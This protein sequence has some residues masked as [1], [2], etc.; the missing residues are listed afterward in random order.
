MPD[1]IKAGDILI[2]KYTSENIHLYIYDYSGGTVTVIKDITG[3]TAVRIPEGCTGL[4]VRLWIAQGTQIENETVMPVL[5]KFNSENVAVNIG[6]TAGVFTDADAIDK[7][8]IVFV[9]KLSNGNPAIENVPYS[10][11]WL[12]TTETN[13]N[14]AMQRVYP[15]EPDKN[16]VMMRTKFGGVYG[17]WVSIGEKG[18]IEPIDTASEDETGK[19]NMSPAIQYALNAYG[20]CKLGAGVYYVGSKITM[21]EGSTLE[22]CGEATEIRLMSGNN[23]VA[24][25]MTKYCTIKNVAIIGAYSD[26]AEEN[27]GDTNGTRYGIH[28]YKA[29]SDTYDTG[30][31]N[32]SGVHLRNFSGAGIYQYGTGGNVEQGLFVSDTHIKNCWA[33]IWIYQNSEFCRYS[34]V[35]ITYCK[36]AC[37]NNGGNNAFVNCVFHAY[38]V[39]F[40]IDGAKANSAHGMVSNSSFCHTGGNTGSAV[41]ASS[42]TNGFLF[43]SCQFWYNS[44]DIANSEGIVF[45]GCAMGK[46][47]TGKGMNINISGGN[48]ILI[49]GCMF[50]NDVTDPPVFSITDNA[51]VKI[52]DCFG[53]V[54]GN[55]IAV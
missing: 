4:I 10:A 34:N 42:V 28:Y 7:N 24:F 2:A 14:I 43:E 13:A 29:P 40:E 33:G 46:G 21:P 39:G 49:I 37:I 17:K 35:Q 53:S 16:P 54:S 12:E 52:I 3:N 32:I 15:L 44:I 41:S 26:L 22:G 23:K 19:T 20:H 9:S 51:K 55:A 38:T 50:Q 27:F 6:T 11:C 5:L 45:S 47:T 25:L 31:C 30:Y 8:G 1:G 18:Y 48:T 36:K